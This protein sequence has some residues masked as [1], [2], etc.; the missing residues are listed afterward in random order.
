[1]ERAPRRITPAILRLS[2]RVPWLA[3]T[4]AADVLGVWAALALVPDLRLPGPVPQQALVVLVAIG[5]FVPTSALLIRVSRRPLA[6]AAQRNNRAFLD[7][8]DD[9]LSQSEWEFF[10]P[11]RRQFYLALASAAVK[12]LAVL[13]VGAAIAALVWG[14][15]AAIGTPMPL[16]GAGPALLAAALALAVSVTAAT[17]LATLTKRG[18]AR[19][20]VRATVQYVLC[21]GAVLLVTLLDGV[22]FSEGPLWHQ[23]L[24]VLALAALFNLTVGFLE[25]TL[26]VPGVVSAILVASNALRLWLI[27]WASTW[28]VLSLEIS[29]TG[30]FLLALAIITVVMAPARIAARIAMHKVDA[31]RHS[32]RLQHHMIH[33]T[34]HHHPPMG[35]M[36][37]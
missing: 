33:D 15:Y 28:S 13:A 5:V 17:A 24:M 10:A 8:I 37:L 16:P 6:K 21:A 31:Q 30:T 3:R 9:W 4:V 1:M 2:R 11:I 29:G 7:D 19:G 35:P 14:G 22:Q 12:A 36:G 26:P 27:A 20:A 34:L 32:A 23:G 18:R 25:L